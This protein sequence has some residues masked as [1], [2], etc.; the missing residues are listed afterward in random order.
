MKIHKKIRKKSYGKTL[1]KRQVFDYNE[2]WWVGIDYY[3]IILKYILSYIFIYIYNFNIYNFNIYK[4]I[5]AKFENFHAETWRFF[6]IC[7]RITDDR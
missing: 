2:G 1:D 5:A 4:Y 3:N 6:A 7:G